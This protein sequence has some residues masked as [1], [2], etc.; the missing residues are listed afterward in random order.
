MDS[1]RARKMTSDVIDKSSAEHY[2]WGEVCDGWHLLK[3]PGLSVIHER[4]PAG[5]S[6][7]PHF[8]RQARQ[9][10]FVLSGTATL[11]IEGRRV[12]FGPGQGVHVP[13][14]VPHRFF[15]ASRSDVEFLV[16]SS[17]S[18]AGDRTNLAAPVRQIVEADDASRASTSTAAKGHRPDP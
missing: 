12:T 9:F 16:I 2:V 15:N 10:F 1:R 8:H 6:E 3:E 11:E 17:P 5:A 4:V 14:G 18:T 13:P 7:V